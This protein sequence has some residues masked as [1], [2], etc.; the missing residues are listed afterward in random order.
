MCLASLICC[1]SAASAFL[2]VPSQQ[3][4]QQQQQRQYVVSP[5]LNHAAASD[6]SSQRLYAS[7]AGSTSDGKPMAAATSSS[8]NNNNRNNNK[9]IYRHGLAILRIPSTS[10]DRI[11]NEAI[12]E[13]AIQ[14]THKLSVVLR[15]SDDYHSLASLRRYVG[16]VYSTLW[17]YSSMPTTVVA[18]VTNV[19]VY[20]QNLPNAAPEQW[21]HHRDDLDMVCSHDSICGWFSASASGRG[22]QFCQG[23]GKG[24]LQDHVAALN[25]DRQGRG[26]SPVHALPVEPWPKGACVEFQKENHVV[27]MD[28]EEISN[29]HDNDNDDG[30]DVDDDHDNNDDNDALFLGG[31][32]IESQSLFQ[33]VCVGG[34]F[35]GMHYGHRK[36]LTLAV[37]SVFPQTGK[38]LVGVTVDA[39]LTHKQYA[40][41]IPPL[42]E[43]MAGV[44]DFLDRLAPGMKN[45]VT[46]V[47]I[48][49]SYGPPGNK[50][51]GKDFDA[52]VLS[53]ETLEN[54]HLLNEYRVQELGLKPLVL[55]CTRRT[56]PHGM[57]ST[58]LRKRRS[59]EL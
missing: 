8:N 54:G 28:D 10:I 16:E 11:A 39:M 49:D 25:A 36:L 51:D 6:T 32:R 37:S 56:E 58:A 1:Q 19:V 17:D 3:Q 35:D 30:C 33:T 45:R 5:P 14:Q 41:L 31:A 13:T 34:T 59:L 9:K 52:L 50:E 57:S 46:I 22:I 23:D 12:L 55:L 4:Q 44:R 38:L 42:A 27:F 7:S 24:G 43:R 15:A 20:A 48:A 2:L 47:P 29:N 26:L 21:I 18:D 40:S 53:H